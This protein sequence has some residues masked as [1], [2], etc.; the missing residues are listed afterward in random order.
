MRAAEGQAATQSRVPWCPSSC[1]NTCQAS[2]RAWAAAV[3]RAVGNAGG[4]RAPSGPPPNMG[5]MRTPAK[6][7]AAEGVHRGHQGACGER[8]FERRPREEAAGKG[9]AQ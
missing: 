4:P 6:R 2:C 9:G 8:E 7:G 5:C 3:D 1:A